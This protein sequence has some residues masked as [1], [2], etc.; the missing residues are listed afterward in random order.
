MIYYLKY[1]IH[2]ILNEAAPTPSRRMTPWPYSATLEALILNLLSKDP[3]SRCGAQEI[4]SVIQQDIDQIVKNQYAF[5]AESTLTQKAS[6]LQSLEV[7]HEVD[8]SALFESPIPTVTEIQPS[9]QSARVNST[10]TST[11]SKQIKQRIHFSDWIHN[12]FW[13]SIGIGLTLFILWMRKSI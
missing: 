10:L 8:E 4:K 5:D 3:H 7:T 13:M 6:F 12:L 11:L 9:I 2:Q 1:L